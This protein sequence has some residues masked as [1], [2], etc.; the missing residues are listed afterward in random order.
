MPV[1]YWTFAAFLN[2]GSSL[3]VWKWYQ[4]SWRHLC[5][6]SALSRNLFFVFLWF[7]DWK[8]KWEN[9][10][11]RSSTHRRLCYWAPPERERQCVL[12]ALQMQSNLWQQCVNV[13]VKA[14][15]RPCVVKKLVDEK[16]TFKCIF[17]TLKY[18]EHSVSGCW[19]LVEEAVD[20]AFRD[21][22]ESER[23]GGVWV[24][25]TAACFETDQWGE[26]GKKVGGSESV[27]SANDLL[28]ISLLNYSNCNVFY[29]PAKQWLFRLKYSRNHRISLLLNYIYILYILMLVKE[30]QAELTESRWDGD[31][32]AQSR[33]SAQEARGKRR[34]F[35]LELFT[36]RHT[37]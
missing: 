18:Q 7:K 15:M 27:T 37:Q 4:S 34:N 30:S 13:C 26:R 2:G 17:S 19:M 35:T 10:S 32:R 29:E 11:G 6:L 21:R 14:W 5:R 28:I 31:L 22:C 23:G 24:W 9:L 36:Y 3:T 8:C 25:M 33:R 12:T 16:I 20:A 1:R